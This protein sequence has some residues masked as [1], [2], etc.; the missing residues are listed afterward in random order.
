MAHNLSLFLVSNLSDT[1][2]FKHWLTSQDRRSRRLQ[3]ALGKVFVT[4]HQGL[5]Q[6]ESLRPGTGHLQAGLWT[7]QEDQEAV[8]TQ[9]SLP[10]IQLYFTIHVTVPERLLALIFLWV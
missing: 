3:A 8:E 6:M 7:T 10:A 4:L 1:C 9:H 2:M 5:R